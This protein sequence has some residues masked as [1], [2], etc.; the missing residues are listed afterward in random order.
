MSSEEHTMTSINAI[1]ASEH[2]ADLLRAASHRYPDSDSGAYNDLAGRT[3]ALRPAHA[4]ET[5][6]V[7]QLAELDDAPTLDGQ[8]LLALIDGRPVA[9]LSLGDGRVVADP[10]VRTEEAVAL[11]RLQA[12]HLWPKSRRRRFRPSLRPRFA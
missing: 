11:L 4:D 2:R 1:I 3:V 7:E 10:F 12:K 8:V 9:A 5:H 6:V